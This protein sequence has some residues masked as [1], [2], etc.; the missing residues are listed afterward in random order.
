MLVVRIVIRSAKYQQ[1]NSNGISRGTGQD[2]TRNTKPRVHDESIKP[3]CWDY[4]LT[5]MI[6]RINAQLRLRRCN[7]VDRIGT[8][9]YTG[10]D[11]CW[12]FIDVL[13]PNS[14]HIA[15]SKSVSIVLENIDLVLH[16]YVPKLPK[17]VG[18][19]AQ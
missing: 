3:Y 5:W 11:D 15:P 4:M 19:W 1:I 13:G 6:E 12:R 9:G 8:M 17:Y 7:C 10:V 18:R 16:N 2:K 14:R